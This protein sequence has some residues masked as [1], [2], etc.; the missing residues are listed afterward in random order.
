V[1]LGYLPRV[2]IVHTSASERGQIYV[3][4]VNWMLM[5]ACVGL[6]LGFRSSTNL[7]AAYGVA[8]TMT[9]VIT[10]LL[11]YLVVRDRFHWSLPAAVALC[12]GFLVVD[13]A[14]LGANI[15]K[16]PH[17]GWFP[18]I[19][20]GAVFAV[21]TT[22][23]TGRHIIHE[24]AQRGR[25]PLGPF[26]DGILADPD[27]APRVP[28][29]AV[30]MFETPDQVPPP[31]IYNF[32]SNHV[33]HRRVLTVNVVT[34]RVP[35]RHPIDRVEERD[36]GHGITQVSLHYGYLEEPHV[37]DD[38]HDHLGVDPM[39]TTYFLG[40]ETVVVTDR[41]GMAGWREHL[42]VLIRRN[43]TSAAAYFNLPIDR[44]IEISTQVEL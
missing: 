20:G 34:D 37:A 41:P 24:R 17:G 2:K 40:K 25:T 13:L 15:P 9:M 31:L 18:I 7:A 16:I 21:L 11:Y 3:P 26:L 6:V 35:R 14:F 22:W 42:F 29:T 43:A 27:L 19:V 36:L 39:E 23:Y 10:T 28:G 38:L 8:V 5:V 1:Q 32:R 33:L 4:A 30:Y 12:G 44:V